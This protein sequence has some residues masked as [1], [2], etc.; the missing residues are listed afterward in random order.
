ML[1]VSPHTGFHTSLKDEVS[2]LLTLKPFIKLV[3]SGLIPSL[4]EGVSSKPKRDCLI[5]VLPLKQFFYVVTPLYTNENDTTT[6]PLGDFTCCATSNKGIINAH[7]H[8]DI[9]FIY[10]LFSYESQ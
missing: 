10:V 5:I 4:F 1:L 2:V 6:L 8:K 9:I 3:S 7:K